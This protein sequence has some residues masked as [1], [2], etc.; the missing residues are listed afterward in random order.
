[1]KRTQYCDILYRLNIFLSLAS[2]ES[3]NTLSLGSKHKALVG[4]LHVNER[5]VRLYGILRSFENVL[6]I[7]IHSLSS[8]DILF[9]TELPFIQEFYFKFPI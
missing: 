1:M 6:S 4:L 2:M 9:G 8:V 5:S 7:N 3:P